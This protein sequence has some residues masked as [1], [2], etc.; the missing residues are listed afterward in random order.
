MPLDTIVVL[1]L[2]I[3][4]FGGLTLLAIKSRRDANK[5]LTDTE[6]AKNERKA[7]K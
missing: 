5:T 6:E 3:A 1:I 7:R 4:F 2:A